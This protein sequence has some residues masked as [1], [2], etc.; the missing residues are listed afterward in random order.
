MSL[1]LTFTLL[2]PAIPTL[3]AGLP[4]EP[5]LEHASA[6]EGGTSI[7][8]QE[9]LF[10]PASDDLVVV[11]EGGASWK[12]LDVVQEYSRLTDQNIQI[13][14]DTRG[15]LEKATTGLTGSVVVPKA[16]VQSFFERLLVENGFILNYRPE[17]ETRLLGISWR[18]GSERETLRTKAFSVSQDELPAW[19]DHSAVLITTAVHLPSTD[20]RSLSNAL[21][22]SISDQRT[23]MILPATGNSLVLLGFADK[24]VAQAEML[25]AIDQANAEAQTASQ[26]EIRR[27]ALENAVADEVAHLIQDL[28]NSAYTVPAEASR[29]A[30]SAR[31][32]VIADQRTNALIVMCLPAD[33]LH[34]AELVS[35]FDVKQN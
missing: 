23:Q 35:L 29:E 21:R 30:S 5:L 31:T 13:A 14:E 28:A 11:G 12:M 10:R 16:E 19:G 27:F 32:R 17:S 6:P 34:V 9:E 2:T 4:T 33:M 26:P 3:A 18:F 15:A 25:R 22:S 8:A 24:V 1:L 20:V 7:A